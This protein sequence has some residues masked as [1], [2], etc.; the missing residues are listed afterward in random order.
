MK[1]PATLSRD[2][3]SIA[4]MLLALPLFL[5]QAPAA[6]AHSYK[7]GSIEIGHIWAPP[8]D[9]DGNTPVYVPVLNLGDEPV[10]L[11][12]VTT[13]AAEKAVIRKVEND[14]A[15]LVDRVEFKPGK[16]LALAPWREHIWLEHLKKPLKAGDSF[17]LQLDFGKAGKIEVE[18]EVEDQGGD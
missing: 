3:L 13:K 14:K 4:A 9:A 5:A 16:P 10:F 6:F 7:L 15:R 8:P 2:G 17:D 1:N 18:V 11:V 12:G